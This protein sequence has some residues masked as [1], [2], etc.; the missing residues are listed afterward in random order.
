MCGDN[1]NPY[2]LQTAMYGIL[3]PE[4]ISTA[5]GL[6]M[7]KGLHK[8]HVKGIFK[9]LKSYLLDKVELNVKSRCIFAW[10]GKSCLD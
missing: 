9:F 1:F 4:T 6:L 8:E 3:E 5:K 7:L 10:S 2:Q